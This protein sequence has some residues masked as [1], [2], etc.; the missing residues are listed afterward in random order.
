M[1]WCLTTVDG[2]DFRI[3]EPGNPHRYVW[4]DSKGRRVTCNP[5]WYSHKFKGPGIR[6]EIAVNIQT[7]EIVWVY[8]PFP[9]G[10]FPDKVIF[11]HKLQH[12]LE[13]D[14]EVETDGHYRCIHGCR[15]K[16]DYINR[17]DKRAKKR[18]RAR[19][20]AVNRR[21]KQFGILGGGRFRHTLWKHKMCVRAVAVCVQL[22]FE[23]HGVPFRCRY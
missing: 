23:H 14:E 6:C 1:N 20:E 13:E 21:F 16:C 19:Q 5:K 8:G 7:G 10:R 4:Y 11:K 2:T 12:M 9:C 22:T 18:A 3:N 15:S 17:A